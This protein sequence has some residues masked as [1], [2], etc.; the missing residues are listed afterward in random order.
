[1]IFRPLTATRAPA[2]SLVKTLTVQSWDELRRP[3][4]RGVRHADNRFPPKD[5]ARQRLCNPW[6]GLSAE[7]C[8]DSA[9]PRPLSRALGYQRTYV[10]G[11]GG[12]LPRI[13]RASAGGRRA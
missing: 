10:R 6:P 4:T 11:T 3:C 5:Q 2:R 7:L 12:E 9:Q 13:V 8:G 1:V